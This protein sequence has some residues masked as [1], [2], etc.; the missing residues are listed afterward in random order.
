MSYYIVVPDL[1]GNPVLS[2]YENL[3]CVH[4][5]KQEKRHFVYRRDEQS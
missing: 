2:V 5:G 1:I 3:L 4:P